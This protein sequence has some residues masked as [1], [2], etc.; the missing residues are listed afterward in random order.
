[1]SL[2]SE[3]GKRETATIV[4]VEFAQLADIL[5]VIASREPFLLRS[6]HCGY[7]AQQPT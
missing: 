3:K 1:M 6:V 2:L 4:S 5:Q 7:T